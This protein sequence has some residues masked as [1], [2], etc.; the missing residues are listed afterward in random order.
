MSG[1][2]AA[3]V[4]AAVAA[5]HTTLYED[6]AYAV[7]GY[8]GF[9]VPAH[10]IAGEGSAP[11]SSRVVVKVRD[12]TIAHK[13]A[14][15]G[16][17]IADADAA[18][19][20]V[21]DMGSNLQPDGGCLVVEHIPHESGFPGEWLV[22]I[23][24]T[25]AFG[26]IV[27]VAPGGSS[28]EWLGG[29]LG[30]YGSLTFSPGLPID[31][32]S[33]IDAWGPAM[34]LSDAD[35]AALVALVDDVTARV[36]G[37]PDEIVEFEVNPFVF[38]DGVPVALDALFRLGP[39]TQISEPR[40]AEA[41]DHMLVPRTI[42]IVGVSERINPGRLILRNVLGFGFSPDRVTVVKS[43]VDQIDGVA[44]VPD[45]ASLPGP[46]DLLVVAVGAG[47]VPALLSDVI[48]GN[49]ARSVILVSGGLGEAEGSEDA[50]DQV[51]QIIASG[52]SRGGPVVNGA[53]C[54]GVRSVPGGYDTLFI[55]PHKWQPARGVGHPV[56][57]IAQSGALALSRLDRIPWLDPRYVITVGNQIDLTVG[58][59][60]A[61]VA[62]DPAVEIAACYV[63]GFR[64][65]DGM[66]FAEATRAITQRGGQVLLLLGGRTGAGADAAVS[67]TASI[68]GDP[69]V[70]RAVAEQAGAMVAD[71]LEEFDDLL[72]LMVLLRGRRPKGV[73]VGL[74]SNAGFES[75]AMA[76]AL[77]PLELAGFGD[78]TIV[79]LGNAL[80]T[81]GVA[82][83]VSARNPLDLT[84]I[85][86]DRPFADAVRSVLTD[87]GVDLAVV[88]CVP[89]TGA[90]QTLAAGTGHEE[91][92]G[93][94]ESIASLLA[95]LA[96]ETDIPWVVAIDAGPA[97][98]PMASAIESAGIPVFR[99][100][101]RAVEILG[102]W[103]VTRVVARP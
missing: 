44:C 26:T 83:I 28:A 68:A 32:D 84:P 67:H 81:A 99:T 42:A 3:V 37:L 48:E 46:V 89:F 14:A 9:T 39:V 50:E 47:A 58:D 88:G 75:V 35:R 5:G 71:S 76:D 12:R 38:V 86:G 4:A 8:L 101:D 2:V 87:P 77:G 52:R 64:P 90:L 53:N 91:D 57:V 23:R 31:V 78:E 102:K 74:V 93:N 1:Q 96:D 10:V 21:A 43:G 24:R 7:A 13:A 79:T 69:T 62:S 11:V 63:E 6:Q 80:G 55:P 33:A 20:V 72:R 98:D 95:D 22:G 61:H 73:S 97:Y 18:G 36:A 60:L 34:A 94:P 51:R 17:Q 41:I 70:A 27:T 45:V 19:E 66:R 103:A 65:G 100:A 16:V 40:S 30:S 25:D 56:A 85:A 54:L 92:V 29:A 82:E 59:H 15:G 49:S